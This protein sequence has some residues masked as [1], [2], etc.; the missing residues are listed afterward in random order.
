[1]D[2]KETNIPM[3]KQNFL[4]ILGDVVRIEGYE[5]F[6]RKI[7]KYG[8]GTETSLTLIP[9]VGIQQGATSNIGQNV[10]YSRITKDNQLIN[11]E[12]GTNNISIMDA[13]TKNPM[14]NYP[15]NRE[16]PYRKFKIIKIYL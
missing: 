7:Y 4:I 12:Q 8:Q 5:N 15:G 1:M 14:V 3:S 16:N 13:N 9:K 10:I 2:I 11:V 6:D